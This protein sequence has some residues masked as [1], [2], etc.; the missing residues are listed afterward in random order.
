MG[1]N[2]KCHK[3]F[4]G[5]IGYISPILRPGMKV[6]KKG[7]CENHSIPLLLVRYCV[8]QLGGKSPLQTLQ[9]ELLDRSKG[10]GRNIYAGDT[11]ECEAKNETLVKEMRAGAG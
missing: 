8:L 11:K 3:G 7:Y 2:G 6:I 10:G 5:L 9:R 1:W 4:P